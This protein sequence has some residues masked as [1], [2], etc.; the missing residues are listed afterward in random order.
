ML[1]AAIDKGD[2]AACGDEQQ[3]AYARNQQ[4]FGRGQRHGRKQRHGRQDAQRGADDI[5]PVIGFA[6]ISLPLAHHALHTV[7]GFKGFLIQIFIILYLAC[8]GQ[9]QDDPGGDQRQQDQ[10]LKA[11][12]GVFGHCDAACF[13]QRGQHQQRRG[14]NDAQEGGQRQPGGG[15]AAQGEV[16]GGLLHCDPAQRGHAFRAFIAGGGIDL[17][18]FILQQ[19]IRG[20][21]EQLAEMHNLA[22]IGKGLRALPLGNGLARNAEPLGQLLLRPA[23]LF[24]QGNQLICKNHKFIL[25]SRRLSALCR[26]NDSA[27]AGC[28]PESELEN[29][30][31]SSCKCENA[32]IHLKTIDANRME[33]MTLYHLA[34]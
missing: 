10:Q 3:Q 32:S 11:S 7:L 28:A 5:Q 8:G 26:Q 20:Y 23:R 13:R 9:E 17:L 16:L 2:A 14:G 22:D 12:G 1:H 21:A 25:L 31:T 4:H 30:S 19:V 15:G 34:V 33:P 24:T 6:E 29:L 27:F 18:H